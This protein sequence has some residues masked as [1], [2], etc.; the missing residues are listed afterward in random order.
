MSDQQRHVSRASDQS[1]I[2][3]LPIQASMAFPAYQSQAQGQ[4]GQ[5]GQLP[6]QLPDQG[7]A[8]RRAGEGHLPASS[9]GSQSEPQAAATSA[10]CPEWADGLSATPG[11]II[12][13]VFNQLL[14]PPGLSARPV[15][16]SCNLE[17][18]LQ[19]PATSSYDGLHGR[20]LKL[21]TWQHHSG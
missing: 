9:A 6:R 1:R 15:R 16:P 20:M 11:S 18:R 21:H 5:D 4:P 2:L 19:Q 8:G 13:R 3:L 17:P 7:H 12:Q 10:C 14:L